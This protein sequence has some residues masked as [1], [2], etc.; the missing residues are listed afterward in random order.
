MGEAREEATLW[1]SPGSSPREPL[2]AASRGSPPC[3]LP[4]VTLGLP[5]YSSKVAWEVTKG[6]LGPIVVQEAQRQQS[7]PPGP[8][9]KGN[10]WGSLLWLEVQKPGT[11]ALLV[12]VDLIGSDVSFLFV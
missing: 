9:S 8:G 7:T 6:T 10:P 4:S 1:K 3:S 2:S 12:C 11:T 5:S